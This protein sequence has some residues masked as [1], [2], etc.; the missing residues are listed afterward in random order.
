M[1]VNVFLLVAAAGAALAGAVIAASVLGGRETA[2]EVS[3]GVRPGATELAGIP[4]QG[5][6]L[7]DPEA[8]R[9][10]AVYGDVQCPYCAIWDEASLPGIV[11]TY[12]RAG[13][14]RIVFRGL[15]FIGPESDLGLRAVLAASL[16]DKGWNLLNVLY[17]NQGDEN[18]GWLTE[19]SLRRFGETVPGLDVDRMLSD[20][21][22][23]EI[24]TEI[25][26]G[27]AAAQAG[28]VRGTPSFELGPTGGT[29]GP[30]AQRELDAALAG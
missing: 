24:E 4:Q 5:I 2:P 12:V 25:A 1:R 10:L 7:G 26:A 27:Q 16:Q 28:G 3:S 21:R 6:A 9:T 17:A 29:L 13:S 11:D 8:P 23:S 20:L 22:A 19:D 15:A 30:V 14:L 18:G